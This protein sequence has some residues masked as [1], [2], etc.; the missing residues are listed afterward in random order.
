MKKDLRQIGTLWETVKAARK[1]GLLP[2]VDPAAVEALGPLWEAM[3][4]KRKGVNFFLDEQQE[5]CYSLSRV[6]GKGKKT[7]PDFI[8]YYRVS[9]KA[10]GQSGLGLD[11]Q[12]KAVQDFAKSN[13]AKLAKEFTEVE[14]GGKTAQDRPELAAALAFA[15]RGSGVLVVAKL[16]RLARN[17]HFLSGLMNSGVDFQAVDNPFANKL[18]IHIMAAMAEYEREAISTRTKEGLAQAKARG[19]KLGSAR[20]GHWEGRESARAEGGRKG[21]ERARKVISQK[22]REEYADILPRIQ[23]MRNEGLTLKAIAESLNAEGYKTRRGAAFRPTQIKR[24][25][26]RGE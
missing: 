2:P 15:R 13:G 22:A 24:I 20:P 26:E 17:V 11:A 21:L 14:S 8:A 1:A 7:M 10:Q 6:T 4:K 9:T 18:T 5:N 16:D 23:A 3:K 25:L 19:K 12:R